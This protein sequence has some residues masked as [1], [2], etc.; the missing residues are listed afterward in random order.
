MEHLLNIDLAKHIANKS[1]WVGVG[2]SWDALTYIEDN[3]DQ[4]EPTLE[5]W[6]HVLAEFAKPQHRADCA[7]LVAYCERWLARQS[8]SA[9][10]F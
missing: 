2:I 3:L 1:Y 8:M 7:A 9:V 5:E 10:C 4:D 6:E